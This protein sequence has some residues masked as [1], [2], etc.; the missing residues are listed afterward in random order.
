MSEI[1]LT[2]SSVRNI[3]LDIARAVCVLWVVGFWHLRDYLKPEVSVF[4]NTDSFNKTGEI[5]TAGV[6]SM[7]MLLSGFFLKKYTFNT[8][9]DLRFFFTKR[10]KRF[11]LLLF[12]SALSLWIL[13]AISL[14]QVFAIVIGLSAFF[15]PSPMT[16]WFFGVL[17]FFY[18]I[19]PILHYRK[20]KWYCLIVAC[21]IY[22]IL[23][24]V[25]KY[26]PLDSRMLLYFPFYVLGLNL[27]SGVFNF[28]ERNKAVLLLLSFI[29]LPLSILYLQFHFV[30]YPQIILIITIIVSFSSFMK[31]TRLAPV[32][33][34]IALA[35]MVAYLFHRQIYAVII[36]L[37]NGNDDIGYFGAGIML[38]ILFI[39]SGSLQKLYDKLFLVMEGKVFRQ[40]QKEE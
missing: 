36:K 20:D 21:V 37:F 26:H 4:I 33:T 39:V 30:I 17:I 15:M 9:E 27:P 38:I 13:K 40:R 12:L 14:F 31:D 23:L 22:L 6:L 2:K 10:L 24:L 11:Y 8:W 34:Y 18:L 25:G 28:I 19:T 1:N 16:L 3:T 29:L 7:F 32:M 5:I 35:S